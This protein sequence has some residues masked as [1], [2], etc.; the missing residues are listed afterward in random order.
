MCGAWGQGRTTADAKASAMAAAE[1][2]VLQSLSMD[3]PTVQ[4]VDGWAVV[5]APFIDSQTNLGAWTWIVTPGNA[6]R[7]MGSTHRPAQDVLPEMIEHCKTLQR[8][9]VAERSERDTKSTTTPHT[10]TLEREYNEKGTADHAQGQTSIEFHRDGTAV[11]IWIDFEEQGRGERAKLF[12][13]APDLL[14][15]CQRVLMRLDL[16]PRTAIFP[17]SAMREDLRAAIKKATGV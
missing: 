12:A 9:D 16:E 4:V 2:I 6:K 3:Q 7:A 11:G 5:Y 15:V 17:C 10:L 14:E 13:A 1:S 8:E